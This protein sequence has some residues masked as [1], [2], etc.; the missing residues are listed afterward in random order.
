MTKYAKIIGTGSYLPPRRVTNHELA[1]QL[2]EQGIE[3]SDEWIVSRSGISARHW[4][5]PDVTSSTLAVNAAEQAIEAAGIDRQDI[6]LIIVAT[7]TPDFV[8]PSTACIVQEKL[9]ITNHC[10]AF[11]LQAVCSGFVYALATADKFIRSG[12]HRNVLVIGTEVFSRILDFNDRTTCVLFGDG[13]GAVVLSASDEP[14]ILSSAMHSDGS[15]VDILCVPGNVAGGNITGNPFLHMDGQAVFKLA[16]NVLDKVAREAM[17]AASVS[18]DQVDWLIPH[19]A[20]IRIMQGTAKKLGLPAERM[21]ATV[22]EHGN[23]SAASIPLA[24]DVAVRDGR[25]RPGHTVLMEGVGGGFTWGAVL[26]R[27]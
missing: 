19:Q 6:D 13:A 26:L 27:M 5:E 12:S 4:A 22:H 16:V 17:E 8:F 20:N 1:A 25:I 7:S 10:P 11:D 23:T 15:H 2:A 14:G 9:G 21:V 18:P 3:T 24:L